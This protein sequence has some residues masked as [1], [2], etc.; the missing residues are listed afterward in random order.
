MNP[1][2]QQ[3]LFDGQIA[4]HPMVIGELA[5]GNLPGRANVLTLLGGLPKVTTAG[6]AEVHHLLESR[7][8]WGKGQAAGA[9]LT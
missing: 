9:D 5:C 6:D 7:R 1:E 2:L 8:L 3:Q 4:M